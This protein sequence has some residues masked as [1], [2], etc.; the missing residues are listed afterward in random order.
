MEELILFINPTNLQF[1]VDLG[2]LWVDTDDNKLYRYNG[3]SF[4]QIQDTDIATAIANAASAANVADKKITTYYGDNPPTVDLIDGSPLD[5]DDT[6]DLWFESDNNNKLHRWSG[7]E[8]VAVQDVRID[9]LSTDLGSAVT[10][11]S[12]LSDRAD[13]FVHTFFQDNQPTNADVAT[14][15]LQTGDLWIDTNDGNKLYRFNG[16]TF[17]QVQDADIQTAISNAAAAANVADNKITT[18]Y[19]ADAPTVDS[20][21]GSALGTDD[22]GDLWFETDNNNKLH[23]WDGT[24]WVAVTDNRIDDI[25]TDLGNAVTDITTLQGTT[26][27]FVHTF[28][29]G[30]LPTNSDLS[31]GGT[32]GVG[33]LWIDTNNNNTLKRY[34]GSGWDLV[35]DANIQTAISN[36][37][38]AANIADNKI[39][40][41]YG[42]NPPTL[43][44]IDGTALGV[45]DTGDL[46]FES[47]QNNKL[48]R[49]NGSAWVAVNDSRVDTLASDMATAQ[50]NITTLE[51]KADGVVHT[52]YQNTEPTDSDVTN[53]T[54]H[55]G[56]LWIDKNDGNKLY[57][58]NGTS[59][60]EIRDDDIATAI[61]NAASAANI[62]DNKITTY[63][64]PNAPS[65]DAIDGTPLDEDDEGDLWFE[66]DNFNKLYRWSGSAWQSV[67]DTSVEDNIYSSGTT[68]I[69]GG[70]I[71]TGSITADRIK[72]NTITSSS[73]IIANAAITNAMIDNINAS[74]IN[75]GT[76]STS[77]LNIDNVTIDTN[78]SGKLVIG[79]FE[80]TS[81]LNAGSIGFM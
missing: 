54:L 3:T 53:G 69:D 75:A 52:F 57:R 63:Y 66:T 58:Y 25:L 62:A 9:T 40:T 39:T 55:V 7:S 29:Q 10:D 36:A 48:H 67:K 24:Q 73:G 72:A 6:G 21:D 79:N 51:A 33:D 56:D 50:S 30:T 68:T 64:A 78:A 70:K 2:D 11:I 76:I 16:S 71:T 46:W 59:F 41:Y 20:I 61:A 5:G 60:D 38:A 17:D 77:R 45:E 12:T 27:G 15:S 49:W 81:H 31:G 13:G 37:A 4:D 42:A 1:G 14:G 47:D 18:Y 74:K 80:G 19:G 23:R 65:T 8:W 26:D 35:A 34:N 32:I 43:D 22:T 44:S 28:Y